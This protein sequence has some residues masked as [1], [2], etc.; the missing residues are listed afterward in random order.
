MRLLVVHPGPHYGQSDV[1]NGLRYGLS[2][3]GAELTTESVDAAIVVSPIRQNLPM[4]RSLVSRGVPVF[5]LFT[6]SPYDMALELESAQL[7]TGGWTH[8]RTCVPAFREV[9]PQINYLPHAWHP[10]RHFTGGTAVADIPAHDVV[11]VGAAFPE[12]V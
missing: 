1:F 11:F 4:V 8:E 10:E 12:R 7:L 6:E 2:E 5:G 3:L 9:N